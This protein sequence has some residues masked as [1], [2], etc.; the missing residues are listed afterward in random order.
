MS[1]A[2]SAVS[3]LA[4]A[5]FLLLAPVVVRADS[6]KID[7]LA[8][9]S[10][11]WIA[12][13]PDFGVSNSTHGNPPFKA[14]GFSADSSKAD[15]ELGLTGV[16]K[17]RRKASAS[18]QDESAISSLRHSASVDTP[19]AVGVRHSTSDH[20]EIVSAG[21][22]GGLVLGLDAIKNA[23]SSS[24]HQGPSGS[25]KPVSSGNAPAGSTLSSTSLTTTPEPSALSLFGVS[26]MALLVVQLFSDRNR[27]RPRHP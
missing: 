13:L 10:S 1:K 19:D 27:R 26:V 21:L 2:I 17:N 8:T 5:L 22:S 24:G 12:S 6:L 7:A 16:S 15:N 9:L 3:T 4:A 23:A 20:D 11:T 25:S 14:T 18:R